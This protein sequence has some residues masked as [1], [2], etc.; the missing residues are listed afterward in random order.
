MSIVRR[1]VAVAVTS[2]V[3]AA[4]M[5]VVPANAADGDTITTTTAPEAFIATASAQG[6]RLSLF[7]TDITVGAS[8]AL[9]DSSPKAQALGAGVLLVGG[10]VAEALV[11]GLDKTLDPAPACVI[12]LP[13][14]LLNLAAA[15]GDAAV[16]TVG[17][18][19]NAVS[20][21]GV[22]SVE[23]GLS[24][25]GPL[26]DQ[27]A[28]L[29]DQ[30][31]ATVLD[32]LLGLLGNLLN[33]LLSALNLSTDNLV[34]DLLAGLQRA[35]AVL[36]IRLG[37]SSA[38][39]TTD[40]AKVRS[41]GK[42]EGAV[43]ELLPGLSPLGAPL[44]TIT[45]G[46]A[47]ASV[48]VTRPAASQ[49]GAVTAVATPDFDAALVN[50]ALGLPILGDVTNIPVGLGSPLTLLAGTPLQSTIT[51]GG[52]SVSD[53]PNGS[54]VAVAD[55]VSLQLLTGLNG[56]IGLS[57][58]HA[59]AAGGGVSAVITVQQK[60][61]PVPVVVP[62]LARTGGREPWAPM[63]G[64]GLL[65]AALLTRRTVRASQASGANRP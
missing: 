11:T 8:N 19:P 23:I 22:A 45:V 13:L 16:S 59:E 61:V 34:S 4:F 44:A 58:A 5:A 9:I 1:I 57:L 2:T 30:T 37:T 63:L 6:L 54:K 41:E 33:P 50:V 27:L 17:G 42:A 40:A 65:L 31:I 3:V 35:T 25:L 38:T 10:T 60:A 32:P 36:A 12:N 49:T 56:G 14:G 46:Q 21:G 15:C 55:G 52:G 51:L 47:R 24:L 39:G 48:D 53:G 26:V 20:S 18:L 29:L 62:E 28:A 7:G 64:A 43:I